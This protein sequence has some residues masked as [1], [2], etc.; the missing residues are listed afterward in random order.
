MESSGL[1]WSSAKNNIHTRATVRL[2]ATGAITPVDFE[3]F[4]KFS[5][6]R[7]I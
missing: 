7:K 1:N 2:G 4:Q 3:E 5:A 6:E